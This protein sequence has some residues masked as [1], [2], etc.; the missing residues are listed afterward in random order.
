LSFDELDCTDSEGGVR[1]DKLGLEKS[2][3]NTPERVPPA[4]VGSPPLTGGAKTTGDDPEGIE[5]GGSVISK[6]GSVNSTG[7][8]EYGAKTGA[9]AVGSS[10]DVGI[11]NVEGIET[12]V[13][14]ARV[15]APAK[16]FSNVGAKV[17]VSTGAAVGLP[18]GVSPD[19]V[20]FCVGRPGVGAQVVVGGGVIVGG[21]VG[22][23]WVGC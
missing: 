3:P 11:S 7:G 4:P 5:I 17:L 15:G 13:R 8:S 9:D 16:R 12:T 21:S 19:T 2:A 6:G 18:T 10:R 1:I 22:T 20:G 14:G 23:P